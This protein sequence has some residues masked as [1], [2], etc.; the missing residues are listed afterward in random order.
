[1]ALMTKLNAG[2][3]NTHIV[4]S[5]LIAYWRGPDIDSGARRFWHVE[6]GARRQSRQQFIG[7][8]PLDVLDHLESQRLIGDIKKGDR[9]I[10]SGDAERRVSISAPAYAE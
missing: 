5:V 10:F 8:S 2:V 9:F 4:D 1:M 6:D 3:G 7:T